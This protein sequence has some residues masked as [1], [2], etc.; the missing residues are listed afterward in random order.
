MADP[1]D[2]AERQDRPTWSPLAAGLLLVAVIGATD[3]YIGAD[4][5]LGSFYIVAVGMAAWW[6]GAIVGGIVGVFAALAWAVVPLHATVIWYH[7]AAVVYANTAMRIIFNVVVAAALSAWRDVGFRLERMVAARTAELQSLA[8]DLSAAED[9]QRR[10]LAHDIHDA[11]GQ[12]L[13]LLRIHLQSVARDLPANAD[14]LPSRLSA[15]VERIDT[16]IQQTRTLT[17]DLYPPMLDDLGLVPAL[18]GY[19]DEFSRRTDTEVTIS[20]V[21][22][23]GGHT[24]PPKPVA[25]YL[26]RSARELMGNAV[27]HGGAKQIVVA[28]H[29]DGGALRLTVDDDG[30]GFDAKAVSAP[31]RGLGMAAIRQRLTAM[32]GT[33]QVES[34]PGQGSRVILQLPLYAA[35]R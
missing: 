2:P 30:A 21:G 14:G 25:H 28:L 3:H 18:E 1:L 7:S 26:F 11:L 22:D 15:E 27:R 31:R 34:Q 32:G 23:V 9:A 20:Q 10:Q 16:L 17:F 13:S 4:V 29:W 12:N 33:M 8:A 19:A 24:P 35:Q 6:G 5:P